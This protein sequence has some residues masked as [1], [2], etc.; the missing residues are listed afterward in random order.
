VTIKCVPQQI[1]FSGL[2]GRKAPNSMGKIRTADVLRL[3]AAS[4]MSR[5]KSVRRSA[6][7]DVF[8]GMLTKNILNE[9]ALMG[10][11]PGLQGL[12]QQKQVASV[13]RLLSK[14]QQVFESC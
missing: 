12:A 1:L 10:R 6:Q 13:N 11:I 8:A 9:L 3:R 2:G 14:R 4:A 7:D 5:D